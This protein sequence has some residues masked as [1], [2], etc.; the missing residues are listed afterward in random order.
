MKGI[1]PMFTAWLTAP[2]MVTAA[3]L[4]VTEPSGTPNVPASSGED[5]GRDQPQPQSAGPPPVPIPG[6]VAR[7]EALTPS[8]PQAYFLLGEEVAA[9]SIDPTHDRLARQLLSIAYELDR[10]RGGSLRASIC[11]ALASLERVEETRVWLVATAGAIDP[12]YAATDWSVPAI[13]TGADE[14]ALKLATALGL[15]RAGEGRRALELLDDPAVRSLLHQFRSLIPGG[16][17]AIETHAKSWPCPE[18]RNA[19]VST[20]MIQGSP[21]TLLCNTCR[22]NPGPALSHGELVAHLRFEARLLIGIQRSWSAQIVSDLGPP[23]LDPD[24]GTLAQT[25]RDRYGVRP[26]LMY[27]R[28]GRWVSAPDGE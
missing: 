11:L 20:R 2:A 19:R 18:C 28:N 13:P 12:R 1:A 3:F 25:L 5:V 6:L 22:G 15:V 4:V 9:E 14:T 27:Y 16:A 17:V 23:L 24:P 10:K 8:D 7:L 21:Q 26:D